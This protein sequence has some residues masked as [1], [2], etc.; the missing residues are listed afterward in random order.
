[1]I[2]KN[3]KRTVVTLDAGG[4]NFVFSAIR[5]NEQVVAPIRYPAAAD[6]LEKCLSTLKK[7]FREVIDLLDDKP[8]A[9]SFAFPG[10]AD[11]G[12][13]II[14]DL[15]NFPSFRGGIALGPMLE[16]E[17]GIPTFINNDG[18][19]FAYGEALAG[20]LPA[21]NQKLKESGSTR[22]YRHLVGVTLGTGFGGGVVINNELLIGDNS[23]GGDIWCFR[24]KKYT[25]C[26]VEESVSK[27]AVSRVYAELSGDKSELTSKEIFD[28]AEGDKEGNKNAAITAFSEMGEMAGDALAHACTLID[29][30]IV[31]GGGLAGAHKYIIP[32]IVKELKGQ[33]GVLSGDRFARLQ[34]TPYD[35]TNSSDIEAFLSAEVKMISVTGT[36]T[37]F[38]YEA[39]RKIGVAL[40]TIGASEA[41]ALGAYAFALNSLNNLN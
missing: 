39:K 2:Y 25:D 9:I 7:G 1:M 22:Q 16:T 34:A 23:C 32:A 41:I 17:F 29:G 21:I 40:S 30:L 3:D 18:S 38:P 33:L 14:G 4:T 13:G 8:V 31:I 37:L 19:L 11:Y 24:N 12:N 36:D 28:I 6:N 27:R 26:I 5:G 20:T 10:P 15:P 35:L